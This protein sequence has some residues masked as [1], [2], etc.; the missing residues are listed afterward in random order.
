MSYREHFAFDGSG[1]A[2]D[3]SQYRPGSF[4]DVVW[5]LER[6]VLDRVLAEQRARSGSVDYL[7][8]A[9]GT[10]R[11]IAYLEQRCDSARGIDV[12]EQML[13][14][15]RT[16]V[17]CAELLRVDITA[18]GATVEGRYDLVT[19]FRFVLNAE[20]DLRRAALAA[21]A[22]RLKD[23]RSRLIVNTHGNPVSYK[24]IVVPFRRA[25]GAPGANENLLSVAAITAILRE[26]GLEP[27]ETFGMGVIPSPISTRLPRAVA[28]G[29]E[30]ALA[31]TPGVRRLG[32][33]QLLV[34]RLR[35][36]PR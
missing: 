26:V 34:C 14:R 5:T 32:V 31:G 30:R 11:V 9:C 19:A 23:G 7:D 35:G 22:R 20:P 21:L 4:W 17:R 8:F 29:I 36:E 28:I 16:R 6:G 13:A 24:G 1:D 15:A 12:S 33:N 3:D 27:V 25:M 10:G 18:P 2:Y